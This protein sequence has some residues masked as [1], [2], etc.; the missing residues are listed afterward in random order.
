MRLFAQVSLLQCPC[1]EHSQMTIA[2]PIKR[3]LLLLQLVH[4]Q[5]AA[6]L[7]LCFCPKLQCKSPPHTC[8][9]TSCPLY[10]LSCCNKSDDLGYCN[11]SIVVC[12]AS[13]KAMSQGTLKVHDPCSWAFPDT[14][15]RPR[16]ILPLCLSIEGGSIPKHVT[17]L[18]IVHPYCSLCVSHWSSRNCSSLSGRPFSSLEL[19]QT[20]ARPMKLGLHV[21]RVSRCTPL[22]T[23]SR[24]GL[25]TQPSPRLLKLKTQLASCTPVELQV[26]G[27]MPVVLLTV[28]RSIYGTCQHVTLQC[29]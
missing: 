12:A 22:P 10:N 11:D 15:C 18:K 2:S 4:A 8:D 3:G 21:C 17:H 14:S 5:F 6:V 7:L 1:C 27:S 24:L 9:L 26:P 28:I 25:T 23:L 13:E 20:A 16:L 19:K 29:K